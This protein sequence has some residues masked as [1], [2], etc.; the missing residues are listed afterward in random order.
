M[1]LHLSLTLSKFSISRDLD[2]ANRTPFENQVQLETLQLETLY[3][4]IL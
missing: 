2:K 4:V 1:L 3:R